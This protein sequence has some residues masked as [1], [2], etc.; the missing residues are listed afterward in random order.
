[1]PNS[2]AP[3][4]WSKDFVEHLRTVHFTL[5]ALC[6]GLIVLASFPS[7]T[8]IQ[9][10]HE[11]ALE[12][13]EVTN[14]WKTDLFD[15]EAKKITES[16]M[17]T[18]PQSAVIYQKPET[19]GGITMD[20]PLPARFA[21]TYDNKKTLRP[22]FHA[23]TWALKDDI[24]SDL[25]PG[26]GTE[27]DAEFHVKKPSSI[28]SFQRLWDSLLK[29]GS[30][31]VPLMP[32][33]C[34]VGSTME[35]KDHHSGSRSCEI[36]TLDASHNAE[37]LQMYFND[38]IKEGFL[39]SSFSQNAPHTPY[40]WTGEFTN[41]QGFGDLRTDLAN[42]RSDWVVA[43]PIQNFASI[44]FDEQ[45]ILIQRQPKDWTKKY[46]LSFKD[47]FRDLAALD[48]SFE[49]SEIRAAERI[50]DAEAKRTGDAFEA[51]G[52]KIP[53]EIAV[54]CGVLLILAVQLYMLIHL[55]ELGNRLDREAGFEVAW[56]GVYTSELARGM[57]FTSLLL[58]PLCTVLVLDIRGFAITE[59]SWRAWTIFVASLYASFALSYLIFKVLPQPPAPVPASPEA[60]PP[61]KVQSGPDS[62]PEQIF[63]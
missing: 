59:D 23:R 11:Q 32:I 34:F 25:R 43:I 50:L 6:V 12:I 61:K 10:A 17:T 41:I 56:I 47:A 4:H 1:M 8:E 58:L 15:A 54:R 33:E 14:N 60:E 38:G 13:L 45:Q 51:A 44:P 16:I 57:L 22:E 30:I 20:N 62:P 29:A 52:L 35:L 19:I 36:R 28:N 39:F 42:G 63:E 49:Y 27:I 37:S 9:A 46:K 5:V 48:E 7:K 26:F 3:A 31:E 18:N 40:P 53:A 2:Q 24:A 55:R 21:F